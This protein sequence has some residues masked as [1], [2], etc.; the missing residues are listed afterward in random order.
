MHEEM[1][2]YWQG[3]ARSYS[4][5]VKGELSGDMRRVWEAVLASRTARARFDAR[6]A[7]S[8]PRVLDLGCGPGMFSILYAH[9]GCAVTAVDF[10]Q[11]ML[12]QAAE[13]AAAEQVRDRIEFHCEDASDLPF[14]SDAFDVAVSRN[15][16]WIMEDP[17]RAYREWL[18]VLKPGGK[19]LVFDANWYRYLVDP[20]VARQRAL[21][22][23]ANVLEGWDDDAQAT[24]DEEKRCEE[25][26]ASLP[27]TG[28]LR[29]AWDAELL[30]S[31]GFGDVL[32]DEGIWKLVWPKNEQDYYGSTPM[33]LIEAQK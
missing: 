23:E 28:I 25:L 18:R 33:F 5:G 10:S 13:N 2:R 32:V 12:D 26:A 29:P 22:Q 17:E 1:A 3:R 6:R 30:E 16:T 7:G 15:V 11:N 27:F 19:L 14:P 8:A 4:N 9:M 20:A 21:D 31:I 24:S